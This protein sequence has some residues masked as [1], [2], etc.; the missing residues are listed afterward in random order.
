MRQTVPAAH[1]LAAVNNVL[2]AKDQV[3][4]DAQASRGL[5]AIFDK[6]GRP[7]LLIED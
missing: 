6:Q 7:R 4:L 1:D 2:A 3:K 5:S